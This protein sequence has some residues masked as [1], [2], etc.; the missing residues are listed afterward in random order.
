MSKNLIFK[1]INDLLG[2]N[3]HIPYYQRGYRWTNHQ[4]T[5]LLNDI[6]TFANRQGKNKEFYCL[7]PIVVKS[8]NWMDKG[9]N[10]SG[11]EIIDGQQRLT[12]I[13]IILS[14]IAKEYLKVDSLLEDYGRE[15]FSIKYET[16]PGS[17]IFIKDISDDR[18]NIDYYHMWLAYNTIKEWFTNGEVIRDRNDREK[19]LTTI[20]GKADDESSVQVI[21]YEVEQNANS[22]ELFTRL[23]IGKIQ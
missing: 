20:L 18:T 15:I 11:W 21:W 6:W 12:T 2:E 3:F 23:N 22:I 16:R 4:V 10:V 17:E 8:M 13:Y 7:Q 14:Y 5:D 1:T 19:F 9:E